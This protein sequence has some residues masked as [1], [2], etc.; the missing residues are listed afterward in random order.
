MSKKSKK[1]KAARAAASAAATQRR[2]GTGGA[3]VASGSVK[4]GLAQDKPRTAIRLPR[5]AIIAICALLVGA[6]ILGC[7]IFAVFF[8]PLDLMKVNLEK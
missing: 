7:V 6:I 2:T 1:R 3:R 5:W 8:A 4:R